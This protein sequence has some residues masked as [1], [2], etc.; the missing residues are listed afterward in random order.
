[1]L[2]FTRNLIGLLLLL[3]T[4]EAG[5]QPTVRSGTVTDGNTNAP[6]QGATII[7]LNNNSQSV[8]TDATGKFSI[9]AL[10]SDSLQ[11]SYTGYTQNIQM[12]G[13]RTQLSIVLTA[14]ENSKLD[15][16]IV[17]GY[18]TQ[19]R[20][21]FTGAASTVNP[22]AFQNSPS[23][24]VATALQGTVPGLLVR[25]TT[26]QPGS[27]P[28][29]IFRGGT[30]FDGSGSPLIVVD[31][32]VLSTLY[33]LDMND[34]ES[35]NVLKDAASTAIYGARAANG[36]VLITTKK[37]KKGRS[38]VQY[39]IRH[40]LNAP[41]SIADDYMSAADYI[42]MNRMGLRA[43]YLAD[44]LTGTGVTGDKG[45][46][47]GAWG[48]AFGSTNSSPVGLYSTQ[49]LSGSNRQYLDNPDWKLLV[50]PNPF[51]PNTVDSILYREISTRR[52]EDMLMRQTA[53]TEHS[54]SFSG[55]NDNGAFALSLNS[56]KDNGVIIG[57]WLKRI[58][59]N[60]NGQL[61]IGKNITVDLTTSAYN[62]NQG[63]PY[64]DPG[65][66]L[67]TGA[68]GGLMQRFL[69]VAPTVRYY[70]D[71]SGVA[72]P[73]P[74]DVSLG[75]PEYWGNIY[76]NS[77]NQQRFLGS[78]RIEY[79]L[80]PYLKLIANGNGYMQYQNENYFTK[81]FQQGNGGAINTNRA[82]SF[83]NYR[84]I[85]YLYGAQLQF[86]KTFNGHAIS[87]MAGG[88]FQ[89]YRRYTFS[90]SAQG[91]P[92]DL[93]PWLSA[94]ITPSVQNGV[95]V[96][97]RSASSNFPYWERLS[98]GIVR[99]NYSF[100]DKY[101]LMGT[102]RL[103][104]SSR[105]DPSNYYGLFPGVSAG[106]NL[107]N[108]EF[109]KSG[110]I[111]RFIS[112]IKPRISYGENGNLQYFDQNYFPT[113]QVYA[114]TSVYDGLGATVAP[115][116]INPNLTWERTNSFNFGADIGILKNRVTILADYFIRNVFDKLANLPISAQTG[117]TSYTTNL[118]Q[119][120]NRGFE[121]SLNAKVLV[122]KKEN[123]L[124]LEAGATFFTVKNYAI[125]LPFN[126][127]PGNRQSTIQVWDPKNPGQLMQVGGLIEGQRIG[128]D[129]E[130]WAPKWNG[131]YTS[132]DMIAAD[133]NVYNAFLPYTGNNKK[134][135]QL[136]DA[137]WQQ[138]YKN[139]TIDSRQFVYVGR[140]R[141][142]ASGNFFLNT[143]YK[144]ISLY[145]AFDYAYGFMVL[146]NSKARG[147]SQVQGSQNGTIHVLDTW[148]P[149]NPNASLPRYYWANQGRNFATDGSGNN[150]PADLW[151][152]GDYIMLRE[153]SLSYSLTN[154][155][156]GSWLHNKIKGLRLTLTGSNLM[157]ITG[158][159]GVFPEVGGIDNGRY[160]LPR[161]LTFG[162][163]ITL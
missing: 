106:W 18:G 156:L 159:S 65:A 1:M 95:I 24:N 75:N 43:R 9:V 57:S 107:H 6:L 116:Y 108:E 7:N 142:K 162:A 47:T 161:R 153:V 81:A 119:L 86:D 135:K 97:P 103:D 105:L 160:P 41:R 146:N 61:N 69:G 137:R 100:R 13:T 51:D 3:C 134:F 48:W 129:D 93:I 58:N 46:L 122:P 68:T 104:G 36:V 33:G 133:A 11:T 64:S 78:L 83:N 14:A 53:T 27:S 79:R 39:S 158:Y 126:G 44:S 80:L 152:K 54:L 143:G 30:G 102:V 37:G 26:G 148:T 72:I 31:G 76:I 89:D 17:V 90:G 66:A 125:K 60:F 163:Q 22:L 96:N 25:Q 15:E 16:V 124:S 112:S 91:A 45:Q 145:T 34:I 4:Y 77:T 35:M 62:I 110:S 92:T 98:S 40:T 141:P 23:S 94:S 136:G 157:Y 139:D 84:D 140:S 56:V 118:S 10:D 115:N 99:V 38:Q 132:A 127:L 12:V 87:L 120:Q 113:S 155:V 49:R 32:V 73:G 149:A 67:S 71:T 5:A 8:I 28:N 117:F 59:L 55:A 52:R 63:L 144:G 111:S 74:N 101:F 85:Q 42:R 150:P 21:D 138:V 88:E 147:L 123:G 128:L 19:K 114:N 70:N 29:I 50:D 151:E 130:I 121:L 2:A 82:S 154:G 20:K 109:Y 131:I